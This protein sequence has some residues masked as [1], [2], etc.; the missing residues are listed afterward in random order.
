MDVDAGHGAA[1]GRALPP[2]P[3]EIPLTRRLRSL[4]TWQGNDDDPVRKSVRRATER[5]FSV[6]DWT[7]PPPATDRS[8]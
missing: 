7:V 5:A 2:T 1:L 8:D 6:E 4:L 3:A